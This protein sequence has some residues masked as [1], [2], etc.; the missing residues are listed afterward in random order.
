M[1]PGPRPLRASGP[2]SRSPA[3]RGPIPA[4]PGHRSGQAESS[5]SLRRSAGSLKLRWTLLTFV[6]R[7]VSLQFLQTMTAPRV[8]RIREKLRDVVIILR[9]QYFIRLW[10]M[11]IGAGASLAMSPKLATI[12]PGG[13]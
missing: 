2:E 13:L 10:G 9:R 12:N 3:S 4:R 8:T 7:V 1:G 11:D 6:P 5:F